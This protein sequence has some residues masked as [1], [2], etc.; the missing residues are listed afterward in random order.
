MEPLKARRAGGGVTLGPPHAPC[1]SPS[2][3]SKGH[4]PGGCRPAGTLIFFSPSTH[5][6][7]RPWAAIAETAVPPAAAPTQITAAPS[8]FGC[9]FT[10]WE[11]T[12]AKPRPSRSPGTP[13]PD[14]SPLHP[15][16]HV[17]QPRQSC[18]G[19]GTV[20]TNSK[21]RRCL[22]DPRRRYKEQIG[23]GKRYRAWFTD[24]ALSH[25]D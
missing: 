1:P 20:P 10:W 2:R 19:P 11:L 17:S 18:S 8:R 16:L 6:H 13:H 15:A 14:R 4:L 9:L 7:A 12:C 25:R 5:S 3:L 24:G 21:N 22:A 23:K